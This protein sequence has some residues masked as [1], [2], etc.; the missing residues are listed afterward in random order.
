MGNRYLTNIGFWKHFFAQIWLLFFRVSSL[1][2]YLLFC[3][4][5]IQW[6]TN[7]FYDFATICWL[8]I[9]V[10]NWFMPHYCCLFSVVLWLGIVDDR[11]PWQIIKHKWNYLTIRVHWLVVSVTDAIW[12]Q[13]LLFNL[14]LWE[15][16]VFLLL[17]NLCKDRSYTLLLQLFSI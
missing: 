8:K 3:C 11:S 14:R 4:L 10:D 12:S 17:F 16:V 2:L 15:F 5:L 7:V 9:L 6:L 13:K 1:E